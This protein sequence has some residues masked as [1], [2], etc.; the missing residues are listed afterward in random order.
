MRGSLSRIACERRKIIIE[1]TITSLISRGIVE[2]GVVV[3]D[4]DYASRGLVLDAK[5][6]G[7]QIAYVS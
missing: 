4:I 2:A 3:E 5:L 6:V 1:V 7:K